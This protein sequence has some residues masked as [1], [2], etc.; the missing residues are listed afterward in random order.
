MRKKVIIVATL[1]LLAIG[2][3]LI[4]RRSVAAGLD[5]LADSSTIGVLRDVAVVLAPD[6]PNVYLAR[7]RHNA[8]S[9]MSDYN[10]ALALDDRNAEAYRRR[11][12]LQGDALEAA[13]DL[14]KAIELE[15]R[16][17]DYLKRGQY[18]LYAR[19][20][21]QAAADLD[22]GAKQSRSEVLAGVAQ[23]ISGRARTLR[24]NDAS[25]AEP[26]EKAAERLRRSL[27]ERGK[28]FMAQ[29]KDIAA[30]REFSMAAR[31]RQDTDPGQN[32]YVM[33]SLAYSR[34]GDEI[35][36]EADLAKANEQCGA[37][38]LESWLV[39]NHWR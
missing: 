15:R 36:A 9:A 11:A 37:E 26:L 27:M 7:A 32:A 31:L 2:A 19:R 23:E 30:V 18:Y 38:R 3:V 16:P 17:E 12:D 6:D 20:Y 24:E 21:E 10:A 13:R 14:T 33:R 35:G 34:I 1:V 28:A 8:G 22:S 25:L 39:E 4:A 5:A 29:G